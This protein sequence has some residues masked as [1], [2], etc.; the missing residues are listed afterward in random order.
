[1]DRRFTLDHAAGKTR[2][3]QVMDVVA[4]TTV[5]QG[6]GGLRGLDLSDAAAAVIRSG[7]TFSSI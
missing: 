3:R 5:T 6:L 4:L 1:M 7:S 2:V